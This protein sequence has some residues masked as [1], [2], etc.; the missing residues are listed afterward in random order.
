MK[1]YLK[2]KGI[3][4]AIAVLA[5]LIIASVSLRALEGRAGLLSNIT[6]A[7]KAPVYKVGSSIID[8]LE[9][10]YGY[11]YE[12][13][14]LVA[15]NEA[16]RKQLA[17]AQEEAR[18]GAEA[19]E[20]NE[21]LRELLNLRER[22]SDFVFESAKIISWNASNWA[23]TFTISKGESSGIELGD[24][25][26]TE[27][28]ALVGQVIE[29]GDSWA[30]VRTVIDIDMK[31][32]VL[33]GE[34]GNAAVL[35]GEFSLMQDGKVKLAHLT[36]GTL[37]LPDDIV[38]TSG[39]GGRFPQ[40]LIA[41]TILEVQTEAGGQTPYAVVEPACDLDSLSQVFVIKEFDIQE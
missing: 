8:W 23:S 38:L 22:H 20:E 14:Q 11:L 17:Q 30:V 27:Y 16:L 2:K 24:P 40:G 34:T 25:V 4:L 10:V 6:G 26:V 36:E 32:G 5:V 28:G 7:I 19:R 9:G 41:G 1:N 35:M 15:E 33:V 29:I 12:Y 18:L 13:D 39:K 37:L 3:P 21:R 31:V